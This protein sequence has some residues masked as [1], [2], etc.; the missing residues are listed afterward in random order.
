M[1]INKDWDKIRGHFR[2]CFKANFHVAIASVDA[3]NNP[4]VTPIGSLFLGEKQTGFYF[5]KYPS[6]LPKAANMNNKICVLAVNSGRWFWIKSLLSGKFKSYPGLKLYGQ[7]GESRQA[8]Q[9]ELYRLQRRM[10]MSKGM[11]GHTYLWGK[12]MDRVRLVTFSRV[13][14]INLKNMTKGL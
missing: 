10:R 6:K 7:L 13:E 4:T 9:N 8:T 2:I 12:D 1:D 5:E 14:K 3:E 11:K